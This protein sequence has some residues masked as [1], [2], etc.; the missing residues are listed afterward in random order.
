[1]VNIRDDKIILFMFTGEKRRFPVIIEMLKF[2]RLSFP[3]DRKYH[4]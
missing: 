2:G 3:N 1:M 4:I